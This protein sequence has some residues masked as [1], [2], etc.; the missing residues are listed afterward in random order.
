MKITIGLV[1]LLFA[2]TFA[3]AEEPSTFQ[4]PLLDRFVG[5]W[6][7]KGMIAG[8]DVT[9]DLSAAWVLGHQYLRFDEVSRERDD[10]G[11]VAYEATVFI[12]WDEPSGRYVCMWLDI[13]GGGGLNPKGFGYAKPSSEKL[14]LVWKADDGSSWH[15]TFAYDPESD[16]WHLKMHGERDGKRR[17][18]ADA[19]MTRRKRD[20]G[21]E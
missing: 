1:A 4:D 2:A 10:K 20:T 16:S 3:A 12:G 17:P 21:G 18:F 6:V 5:E 9:H 13:T 8:G 11:E 15:T 14:A 7:L 19:K